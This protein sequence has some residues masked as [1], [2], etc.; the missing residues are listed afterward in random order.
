MKKVKGR[1][2]ERVKRPKKN[3]GQRE[4]IIGHKNIQPKDIT[5]K[6]KR[7]RR[8]YLLYYILF[9]VLLLGAF[10][11]LSLTVLFKI[12]KI[13][14]DSDAPYVEAD[15]LDNMGIKKGDNLLRASESVAMENLFQKFPY[16]A[17]IKFKRHLPDELVI[18]VTRE[19]PKVSS[20]SEGRTVILSE[21][22]K[23]LEILASENNKGLPRVCGLNTDQLKLSDYIKEEEKEKLNIVLSLQSSLENEGIR[24]DIIDIRDLSS[25]RLLYDK[26]VDIHFGGT[27]EH[28]YK[29]AFVRTAAETSINE[30]FVGILD[31]SRRP[32][33]RLRPVNIFL[34]ENWPFPDYMLS[35]YEKTL[36]VKPNAIIP[37][38]QTKLETIPDK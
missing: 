9:F 33:A 5:K 11:I 8:K 21:K 20:E 3:T 30:D 36:T 16:I 2:A 28:D 23:V 13:V 25:I 7:S 32:T 17:D 4:N 22:G 18:K 38:E 15:I 35:D 26:R 27:F 34:E 37:K 10:C 14:V 12:E 24:A 31:V 6:R 1:G 29:A 19:I